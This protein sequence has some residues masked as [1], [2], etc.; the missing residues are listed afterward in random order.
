[1]YLPWEKPE[2]KR[3]PAKVM[4]EIGCNHIGSVEI[5]KVMI[6]HAKLAGAYA[7]KFQKRC[8]S[9]LY[10]NEE[11]NAPHP[12]PVNSFGETYGQHR[13]FLELDVGQ[14]AELMKFCENEGIVYSTSVWDK[15]SA[16]E[17]VELNPE[18]IKVPSAVNTDMGLLAILRDDYSG[19]VHISTGMSTP[20][21]IEEFIKF[22]EE[23]DA[24]KDRLVIYACVSGYP[25]P[26]HE[27]NLLEVSKLKDLYGE[28][29]FEVGFS[30]H[31]MGIALDIA[32]YVLGATWIERHFT[33]DRTWKGTDHAASLEQQGLQH[34]VRDVEAVALAWSEKPE[35]MMDIENVQRE[36]LKYK[37][38]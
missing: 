33:L 25:V 15:V 8:M 18:L 23:K 24:A 7:V 11:Y 3:A 35:S 5:A 22:F 27:V 16:A 10:T 13:D 28:R 20:A 2:P 21:E 9:E 36:K 34:L 6:K 31:H 17:I 37:K 12:N 4:A 38:H 19:F 26:H 1:M 32:A 30:G 29:V 14:H